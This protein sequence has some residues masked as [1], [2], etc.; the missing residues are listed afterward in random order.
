MADTSYA[1]ATGEL[2]T[3]PKSNRK[4]TK[5]VK[6]AAGAGAEKDVHLET[7]SDKQDSAIMPSEKTKKTRSKKTQQH[8]L[9]AVDAAGGDAQNGHLATASEEIEQPAQNT[10]KPLSK[11]KGKVSK[12]IA[13]TEKTQASKLPFLR[14]SE[15]LGKSAQLAPVFSHDGR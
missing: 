2:P 5:G 14:L 6:S 4:R 12:Q 8:K 7:E 9:P 15:P 1:S 3:K 10:V 11:G 13:L